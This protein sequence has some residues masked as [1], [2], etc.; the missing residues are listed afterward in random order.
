[1]ADFT[2]GDYK[3]TIESGTTNV[4]VKVVDNTKSSY[5]N[6]SSTVEYNSITYTVTSLGDCFYGCTS[7][8]EPP[9]IPNSVTDMYDCF[10]G[11]SS[12]INAPQIP[13]SVVDISECFM[14]CT[15]LKGNIK[16]YNDPM[17]YIDIFT[18]T[19]ESITIIIED[20]NILSTWLSIVDGYSNVVCVYCPKVLD[21]DTKNNNATIGDYIETGVN[22][23]LKLAEKV[24]LRKGFHIK[25]NETLSNLVQNLS[26]NSVIE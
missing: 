7:L 8:T 16:V 25:P 18:N 6:I 9:Q 17:S 3:Y 22:N 10:Y 2:I 23:T 1:M 15:S 4:A 11:C 24:F 14:G 21:I 12:L 13:N 20:K 26:W 5:S 19:V